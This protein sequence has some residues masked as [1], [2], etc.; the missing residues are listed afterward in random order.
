METMQN[1]LIKWLALTV[2]V[3]LAAWVVS[4]FGLGYTVKVENGDDLVKLLLGTAVLALINATLGRV[5]KFMSKPVNCLTLGLFSLVI[6]ALILWWVSSM[7]LGF[8]FNG[9]L[10]AFVGSLVISAT[11]GLLAGIMVPDKEKRDS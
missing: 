9:F 7:G 8:R 2:A 1:L 10:P 6:N 3:A 11:N 4:L 5:L